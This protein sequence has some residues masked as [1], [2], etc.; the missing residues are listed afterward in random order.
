MN[1]LCGFTQNNKWQVLYSRSLRL[2]SI[3][4]MEGLVSLCFLYLFHILPNYNSLIFP[5]TLAIVPCGFMYLTDHGKAHS[6]TSS[7]SGEMW[8]TD[9]STSTT[10][11]LPLE[12]C[13]CYLWNTGLSYLAV[14]KIRKKR[15]VS[16]SFLNHLWKW[17][18]HSSSICVFTVGIKSGDLPI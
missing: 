8:I 1:S 13:M 7:P 9:W 17:E 2:C 10:S 18:Y 14:E 16:F 5:Q 6:P 11:L 15:D 12:V 4:S 3:C